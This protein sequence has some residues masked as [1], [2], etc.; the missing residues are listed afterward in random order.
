MKHLLPLIALVFCFSGVK[1]QWVSNGP[2]GGQINCLAVIDSD[3]F[4]GTQ[5]N[6]V[7][8]STNKGKSWAPVNN[9]LPPNANVLSLAVSDSSIFAGT[10]SNGVFRSTN[11][12][13]NWI[14][15]D[16]GITARYVA[17]LAA[18]GANIFAGTD[19][20]VFL[21][22]NNGHH[23]TTADKGLN[24]A[25]TD[26]NSLL[27]SGNR[28]FAGDDYGVSESADN[29]GNWNAEDDGLSP[30]YATFAM[31]ANDLYI[32]SSGI[33]T[34]YS[35]GT[36]I[37]YWIP[38]DSGLQD[39]GITALAANG[40]IVYAG[41]NEGGIFLST[42]Y[43]NHWRAVNTGLTYNN[44][45][46]YSIVIS[47]EDVF[48]ATGVGVYVSSD[49]G[50]HWLEA[51]SGLS[52]VTITSVVANGNTIFAGSN[53]GG[54]YE[55]ANDG[56]NWTRVSLL[57]GDVILAVIGFNI[58][59][60]TYNGL[61]VSA[62][63]GGHW[64][65]DTGL[66]AYA[67]S[68]TVSGSNIFAGTDEGVFSSSINGGNW[69]ARDSGLSNKTVY[70]LAANG[71]N[72][73]AGTEFEGVFLSTDNGISWKTAGLPNSFINSLLVSTP[74][75]F[76]GTTDDGL[77]VSPDDA[78]VWT[79]ANLHLPVNTSVKALAKSGVDLLA[80]TYQQGA[81]LSG[82]NGNNWLAI[83]LIDTPITSFAINNASVY[84]GTTFGVW[85][86][87]LSDFAT[88]ITEIPASPPALFQIYPNPNSSGN[89]QLVVD[90][91]LVGSELDIYDAEGRLVFNSKP[92]TQ[93][94]KVYLNLAAGV[95]IATIKG[96]T[97]VATHKLVV[98]R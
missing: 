64:T 80:G 90:N 72:I 45:Q 13:G 5:S 67:Y 51:D 16:T 85:Q 27:I 56:L 62:D 18:N 34:V 35:S 58:F 82:D 61:F 29:G 96:A 83:G 36:N 57:N 50:S 70:S 49:S 28:V 87:P 40:P 47:G 78:T 37:I 38:M 24:I 55:S 39:Y 88:G 15:A 54:L 2:Y 71:S 12:G 32:Y 75:V 92:E 91:I 94:S 33:G 1:A 20:G 46:V 14:E 4:A 86:R 22:T 3:L 30:G 53:Y 48:A 66:T 98:E 44:N 73:F 31:A 79:T 52:A 95:Y 7:F 26:I 63:N 17:S 42:D 77:F 74:F 93:N 11:N 25:S 68:F 19:S 76:A 10:F 41:T 65:L 43:G 84:A 59:E 23:W 60:S 21:S 89:W 69:T 8:I 9:G 6:G 81:F 97:G